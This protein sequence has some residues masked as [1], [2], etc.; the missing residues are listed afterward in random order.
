MFLRQLTLQHFRNFSSLDVNFEPGLVV[1]QGDNAQGKT[2]LL[3]AVYML[4]TTKSARARSDA[5]LV[6]WYDRD[7]LAGQAFAR[8]VGRID[9]RDGRH[10]L[11]ILIREGGVEG[12][13]RKR[14]KVNGTERSAGEVL[15]KVNAVFFSPADVDLVGGG[16]SQRRRFLDIMLCQV[17]SAYVRALN[18]YNRA[19]VQRNSL[20]R[21]VRDRV[22]A[23][24]SREFWDDQVCEVG[25]QILAWRAEAVQWTCSS[26]CRTPSQAD[27][28]AR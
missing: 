8:V 16:P 17:N 3:E 4:A 25:A 21:Q 23:P 5:D 18:R 13:A 22:Q 27:G 6:S 19:I 14:F 2:N 10:V 7:P 26:G 12:P 15:G 20:L 1:L 28:W 9:R 11:E 24:D